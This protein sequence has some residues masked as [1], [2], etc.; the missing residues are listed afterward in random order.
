MLCYTCGECGKECDSLVVDYG[1]GPY[2]FWG[3]RGW[4]T[5]K[6]LVSSCCGDVVLLGGKEYSYG[7]YMYDLECEKADRLYD[8][9]KDREMER[10]L[11]GDT[12]EW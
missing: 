12:G 5:D 4:H 2:E 8:E 7:E 11:D 3:A 6:Q 1:I 9:R 10:I